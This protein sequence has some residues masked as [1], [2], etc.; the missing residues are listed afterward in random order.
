MTPRHPWL[1]GAVVDFAA[2]TSMSSRWRATMAVVLS[3][4]ASRD[5][6]HSHN[7]RSSTVSPVNRAATDAAPRAMRPARFTAAGTGIAEIAPNPERFFPNPARTSSLP[8][9]MQY[10]SREILGFFAVSPSPL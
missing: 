6:R 10:S 2:V 8:A 3:L 7:H 4:S 1:S 9:A 5:D